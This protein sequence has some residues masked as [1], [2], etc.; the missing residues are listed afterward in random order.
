MQDKSK[1]SVAKR[2]LTIIGTVI[3]IAGAGAA[4]SGGA[5]ILTDRAAQAPSPNAADITP[6]SVRALTYEDHYTVT[7]RFLGQVESN[8]DVT[9]SFELGGRLAALPVEEGAAIEKG[10]VVAQLDTALLEA[11]VIRLNASRDAT[12]A[13][14]GFAETRLRRATELL[15]DGFSSQ[16]TLDQA[17]A[18]HDE[19]KARIAE[20]DAALQTVQI[21]IDKSIIRA[22][23]AGRIGTLA[24]E[25]EET[26]GAGQHV[27]SLIETTDPVI[28]VGVPLDLSPE[29]LQRA[30]IEIEGAPHQAELK[31]LRPDIDPVTR[32]RTALFRILADTAPTFGQTATLL[33]DAP[34]QARG[35]WVPMD[36]LQEG[37]GSIW[38]VLVVDEGIVRTADVELLHVQRDGAYVR[39]T[40]TDGAQL[41]RTGAHRV[42]PG[43][44]VA[45]LKAEG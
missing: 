34:V 6:V 18:T 16:E 5:A 44:Q 32:T 45:V 26:L 20:I 21:N 31:Q 8:A 33:I 25:A 27:L 9:L 23:L 1:P 42:V 15:G 7:R 29:M 37:S 40:F 22:P 28:R 30:T 38:T 17:Q 11:E 36:A 12:L 43:Q 2:G 41:I 19:L 14:L 35:A 4:V 3:V 39:G 13:Q 10:D 24:V